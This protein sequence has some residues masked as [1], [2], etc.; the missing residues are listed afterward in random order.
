MNQIENLAPPTFWDDG[1][2][3]TGG[4]VTE[5][6]ST[7]GTET[8]I[9]KLETRDGCAISLNPRV[10]P[11]T[12]CHGSIIYALM[13]CTDGGFGQRISDVVVLALHM[14]DIRSDVREVSLLTA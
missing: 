5:E 2:R 3:L 10:D 9:F 1:P 6:C 7:I 14:L 4:G 12:G 8:N 11:L 13:E